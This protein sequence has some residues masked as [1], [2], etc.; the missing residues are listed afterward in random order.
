LGQLVA[1]YG[2]SLELGADSWP[3]SEKRQCPVLMKDRINGHYGVKAIEWL[4]NNWL[5]LPPSQKK[6]LSGKTIFGFADVTY[7]D[8]GGISMPYVTFCTET[9]TI[10]WYSLSHEFGRNE[11]FLVNPRALQLADRPVWEFIS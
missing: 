6:A 9:P 4:K 11:R 3:M 5:N 7:D 1:T 10:G 8:V 2:L